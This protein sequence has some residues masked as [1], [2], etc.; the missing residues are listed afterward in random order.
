MGRLIQ[1]QQTV[2]DPAVRR[3]VVSMFLRRRRTHRTREH[4]LTR[5]CNRAASQQA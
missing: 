2:S 1:R 4:T 3:S 5:L